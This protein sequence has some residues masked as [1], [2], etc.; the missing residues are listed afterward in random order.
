MI[1]KIFAVILSLVFVLSLAAC[2]E[3]A[4]A[5]V[6]DTSSVE[7]VE[8]TPL[9]VIL[10]G[11]GKVTKG[12]ENNEIYSKV[13]ELLS[14]TPLTDAPSFIVKDTVNYK[15]IAYNNYNLIMDFEKDTKLASGGYLFYLE[16]P[17]CDFSHEMYLEFFASEDKVE[18]YSGEVAYTESER[19]WY[20]IPLGASEWTEHTITKYRLCFDDSG[21]VFKGYVFIPADSLT[22]RYESNNLSNVC[23]FMKSGIETGSGDL[24][25]GIDFKISAVMPVTTFDKTTVTAQSAKGR[26]DLSKNTIVE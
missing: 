9:P 8:E 1:K 11:A 3:K 4:D 26:V 17:E 13:S 23:V 7:S 24:G 14:L 12:Y 25:D 22:Y 5:P 15:W 21:A 16:L 18:Q 19:I 20:S 2:G 6:A 10:L